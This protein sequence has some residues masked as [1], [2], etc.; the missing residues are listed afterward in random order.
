MLS[1]LLATAPR[2]MGRNTGWLRTAGERGGGRRGISSW[3]GMRTTS[4]E[5]PLM[6]ATLWSSRIHIAM[7]IVLFDYDWKIYWQ[8]VTYL[9]NEIHSYLIANKLMTFIFMQN[10]LNFRY[11]ITLLK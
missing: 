9:F 7:K 5:W 2:A 6:P 1:W 10:F 11:Y 4:V 8:D 3:P